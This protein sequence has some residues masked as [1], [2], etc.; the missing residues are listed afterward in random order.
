[1]RFFSSHFYLTHSIQT[2]CVNSF[3][4]TQNEKKKREIKHHAIQN[5]IDN[6]WIHWFKKWMAVAYVQILLKS[7]MDKHFFLT[8]FEYKKR[9]YIFTSDHQ[10]SSTTGLQ[11]YGW[12]LPH[13][14]FWSQNLEPLLRKS[15]RICLVMIKVDDVR[16]K[17]TS[18]HL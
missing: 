14:E 11:T 6:K 12:W 5:I 8:L 4:H 1:M 2:T 10:Y 16:K 17:N 13:T 7:N 15:T 9:V 3:I 18:I